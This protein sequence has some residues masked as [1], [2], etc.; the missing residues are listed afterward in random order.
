MSPSQAPDF[1]ARNGAQNEPRFQAQNCTAQGFTRQSR[2]GSC[3]PKVRPVSG[4]QIGAITL[5][6][7]AGYAKATDAPT[8]RTLP[9]ILHY[10]PTAAPPDTRGPVDFSP[11]QTATERQRP[12]H[13]C[14]HRDHAVPRTRARLL[15][16]F[17]GVAGHPA[18]APPARAPGAPAAARAGAHTTASKAAA[19]TGTHHHGPEAPPSAGSR[20]LSAMDCKAT[21][22]GARPPDPTCISTRRT[23]GNNPLKI[24]NCRVRRP[25]RNRNSHRNI[26]P[27]AP[28]PALPPNT[29]PMR[30]NESTCRGTIPG[31]QGATREHTKQ[32]TSEKHPL[33]GNIWRE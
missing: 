31:R 20:R 13:P 17:P 12:C 1:G 11:A 26:L 32:G 21:V 22:G 5:D 4:R 2:E 30:D 28:A 18:A 24:E 10:V 19:E 15:P 3:R 27:A 29:V 9:A 25:R 23:A 16:R 14:D 33:T 6:K 7:H 8:S